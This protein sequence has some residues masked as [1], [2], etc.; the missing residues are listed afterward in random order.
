M[1]MGGSFFIQ[2]MRLQIKIE[3]K[4]EKKPVFLVGMCFP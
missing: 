2:I 4:I 1:R 3:I